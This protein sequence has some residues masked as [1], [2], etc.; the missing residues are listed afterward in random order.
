MDFFRT[1][2]LATKSHALGRHSRLNRLMKIT[3]F[4]SF[5]EVE[6][7]LLTCDFFRGLLNF[8]GI[9]LVHLNPNSVLHTPIFIH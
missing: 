2:T 3:V 6:F 1:R 5:F 8:Y 9:Q 7:Q 4:K